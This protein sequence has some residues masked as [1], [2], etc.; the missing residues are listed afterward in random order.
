[1]KKVI[2]VILALLF[3]IVMPACST[4]QP[5]EEEYSYAYLRSVQDDINEYFQSFDA[6]GY[7]RDRLCQIICGV[8]IADGYVQ[9]GLTEVTDETIAL[10]RERVSDS[11][12]IRFRQGEKGGLDSA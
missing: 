4:T 9:V 10:F 6:V 3:C 8:Y 2:L 7:S 11:E 12:T 5:A 1:M